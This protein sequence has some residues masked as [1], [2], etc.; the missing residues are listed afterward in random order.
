MKFLLAGTDSILKPLAGEPAFHGL[1]ILIGYAESARHT[2]AA[3][4]ICDTPRN[5]GPAGCQDIAATR[6]AGQ[7]G[8][9]AT[10]EACRQGGSARLAPGHSAAV[11]ARWCSL[12]GQ[13][14]TDHWRLSR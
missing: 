9:A 14:A 1:Q 13:S 3:S 6:P 11:Q 12:S 4:A 7:G 10:V 8:D 5:A 2:V